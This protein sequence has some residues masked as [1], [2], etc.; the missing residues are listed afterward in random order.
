MSPCTHGRTAATFR[1]RRT[2]RFDCSSGCERR[3]RKATSAAGKS[4]GGSFRAGTGHTWPPPQAGRAAGWQSRRAC[5]RVTGPPRA[6]R[7]FPW[8]G[9]KMT[10][11]LRGL[12][13]RSARHAAAA[14]VR[15]GRWT[16]RTQSSYAHVRGRTEPCGG[17]QPGRDAQYSSLVT[18]AGWRRAPP[19]PP[20]PTPIASGTGAPC[21]ACVNV[22]GN[23]RTWAQPRAGQTE[24]MRR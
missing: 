18:P 11:G 17:R 2:G 21:R 1:E 5:R 12:R 7:T 10:R 8:P 3:Q 19:R 13:L 20:T 9:R 6:Q 16:G 14:C 23:M 22:D 15:P 4:V 24:N